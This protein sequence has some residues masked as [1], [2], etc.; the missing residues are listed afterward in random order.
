MSVHDPIMPINIESDLIGGAKKIADLLLTYL[1][2]FDG[3]DI[4]PLEKAVKG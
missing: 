1:G 4:A 3:L 2:E